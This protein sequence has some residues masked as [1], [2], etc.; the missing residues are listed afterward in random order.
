MR[1][2]KKF[3]IILLTIT[4]VVG[5]IF[6]GNVTN[7]YASTSYKNS[8][9]NKNTLATNAR[10]GD[11]FYFSSE[12]A[13]Y[14]VNV[15]TKKKTRLYKVKYDWEFIRDVSVYKDY[16]YFT[17]E[18][19][20][21]SYIYRIKTNG[22]NL[23]C[24]GTGVNP[25]PYRNKIYY[26]GVVKRDDYEIETKNIYKMNLNG[27]NKTCIKKSKYISDF[28][29]YNSNIYYIYVYDGFLYNGSCITSYL[30]KM[31]LNGNNNKKLVHYKGYDYYEILN[32]GG[33]YKGY[34]YIY[35]DQAF[36]K[37]KLSNNKLTKFAKF[38]NCNKYIIG[39][40]KGYLYYGQ[41]GSSKD[42]IYK[43]KLSNNKKSIVV[44]GSDVQGQL[45]SSDYMVYNNK[46]GEDYYLIGTNGKNKIYLGKSF[47]P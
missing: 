22:K 47:I 30:G 23:K 16:I 34:I 32:I 29:I 9:T 28:S 26:L 11:Y 36:Y 44:S 24:L 46:P 1:I 17:Y 37:L 12:D 21:N 43:L 33:F 6:I 42:Y 4:M 45:V 20:S 7:S 25:K 2:L 15:K 39:V 13:L 38:N 3:S 19:K 14:K 40:E 8:A 18:K 27:S 35:T 5:S 10:L 31:N 41:W